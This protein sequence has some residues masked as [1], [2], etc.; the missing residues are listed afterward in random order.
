MAGKTDGNSETKDKGAMADDRTGTG[1][2]QRGSLDTHVRTYSGLIGTMKWSAV[3][4]A[5]L[6]AVVIWLIAT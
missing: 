3:A 4:I 5:V 1:P 2:V 6:V